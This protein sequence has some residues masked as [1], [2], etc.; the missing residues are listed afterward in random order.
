[1]S[2]ALPAS[3]RIDDCLSV[4]GGRLRV[5]G[6]D[7][8]ELA[9]RFGTPLSVVSEDQLRRTARRLQAAFAAAWPEGPVRVL[10]SIKA[11]YA[12]AVRAVLSS[13]GLGCDAFGPAELHAALAGGVEPALI[14]VNGSGKSRELLEQAVA[15]GARVTLDSAREL[16]LVREV[17]RTLGRR[18]AVRFRIRPRYDGLEAA[19]DFDEASVRLAAQRYKP[20]IPTEELRR[21]GR[22]ALAW[23]ELDV[24]GLMAHLG[25]H[26]ADLDL[27]RGYARS[28]AETVAELAAAWDGWLPRELDLGGG[29]AAPRDPTARASQEGRERGPAPSVEE[30]AAALTGSLRE[31]LAAHGI[32]LDGCVLEVEPGRALHADAGLHL[33]TVVNVKRQREPLP[34]T[35]VETDTTEMF[36]LDLIVEGARF[37]VLAAGRA[38]EAAAGSVDVVGCSCGFDVLARQAELPAV[39]PGDVLAFLDTGAYED[40][41]AAN[42]NA[43]P[44][45]ALVLVHGAE[46]EL[47][48]RRETIADVFARDAVPER[49]R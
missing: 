13:E 33:A 9:R 30:Y 43:L 3:S 28:V 22:A 31:A 17:A 40:A 49:L 21:L 45:P 34:W 18:A 48:R 44:R 25:R 39:E 24:L 6:C 7:A 41:C 19:S 47:V 2:V 16:E 27:W 29:F 10:P 26:R 12:L 1:V 20:G 8:I 38:G 11:N 23:P 42:F 32:R 5:E 37:P 36:L 46:A 14:S 15:A 4:E 35:W